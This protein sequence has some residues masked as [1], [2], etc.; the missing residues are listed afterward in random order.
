MAWGAVAA[1]PS[2]GLALRRVHA[3]ALLLARDP[4][5]HARA[6]HRQAR[7]RHREQEEVGDDP[8]VHPAARTLPLHGLR[9]LLLSAAH[10][11]AAAMLTALL[12][13]RLRGRPRD[14]AGRERAE[15]PAAGECGRRGVLG[16]ARAATDAAGEHRRPD[17]G[18]GAEERGQQPDHLGAGLVLEPVPI[19]RSESK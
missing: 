4:E 10:G 12:K 7:Q 3:R 8:A 14:V 16:A 2:S 9:P 17:R 13:T 5:G 18:G 11:L 19:Y 15:A 6:E 1:P